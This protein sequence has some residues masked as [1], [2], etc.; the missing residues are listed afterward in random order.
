MSMIIAV[1]DTVVTKHSCS[2]LIENLPYTMHSSSAITTPTAADS[3]GVAQ[4]R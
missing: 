4:P 1:T 3:V 2:M